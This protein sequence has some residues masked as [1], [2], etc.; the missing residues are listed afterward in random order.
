M[1]TCESWLANL[2]K[3]QVFKNCEAIRKEAAGRGFTK[4]Q[5]SA[6]RKKLNVVAVNDAGMHEGTAQNWFWLIPKNERD[7]TE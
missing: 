2:L 4:G 3:G 1:N 7:D 6:A 5:L